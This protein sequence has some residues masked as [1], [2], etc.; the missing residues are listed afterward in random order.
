[1]MTHFRIATAK[2]KPLSLTK[3]IS[4]PIKTTHLSAR[5]TVCF[6][7]CFLWPGAVG[8]SANYN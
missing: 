1:M 4:T 6:C 8:G 2:L 5:G 7:F 3:M